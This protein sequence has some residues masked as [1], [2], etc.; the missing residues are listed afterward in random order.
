MGYIP[1][2]ISRHVYNVKGS[3]I[4]TKFLKFSCWEQKTFEKLKNVVDSLYNYDCSGVN[5]EESSDEEEA[6]IVIETNLSK[7]VSY[8]AGDQSKLVTLIDSTT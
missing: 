3:V 5:D 1:R 8:T 2:E 4:S 6:A 7:S